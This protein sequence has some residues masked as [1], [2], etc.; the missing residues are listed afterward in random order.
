MTDYAPEYTKRER[1]VFIGKH[2]ACVFLFMWRPS[3]GS[4][5]GCLRTQEMLI[6]TSMA[7]LLACILLCMGFLSPCLYCSLFCWLWRKENAR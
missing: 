5:I 2:L 1:I 6:V 4:L 3:F 7:I